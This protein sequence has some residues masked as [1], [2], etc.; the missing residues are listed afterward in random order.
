MRSKRELIEKFIDVHM[1]HASGNQTIESAFDS[2]W[3]EEK[4][5][6]ITTI[7][8]TEGLNAGFLVNT[9][10]HGSVRR[11]EIR[12][13]DIRDLLLKHRVI[14]DLEPLREMRLQASFRPYA[15]DA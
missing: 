8:E 2:F 3:N 7:C 11:V 12:P 1:P 15:A 4:S 13:D 10:H 6:A 9:E 5:K 14:R